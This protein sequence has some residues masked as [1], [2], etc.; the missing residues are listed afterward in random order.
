MGD[1]DLIEAHKKSK[2]CT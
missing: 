1:T 2:T